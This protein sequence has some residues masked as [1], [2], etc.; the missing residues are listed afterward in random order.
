MEGGEINEVTPPKRRKG[1]GPGPPGG[2]KVRTQRGVT[3]SEFRAPEPSSAGLKPGAR[4]PC[5]WGPAAPEEGAGKGMWEAGRRGG[6]HRLD[7]HPSPMLYWQKRR[8]GKAGRPMW[9]P[10]FSLL[11]K[12]GQ[13]AA[14]RGTLRLVAGGWGD[15]FLEVDVGHVI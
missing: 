10:L 13:L 12:Q 14:G 5:P 4:P 3:G 11:F 1:E 9:T 6:H 8:G 15:C 2:G 7:L